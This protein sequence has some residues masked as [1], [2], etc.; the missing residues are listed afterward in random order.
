MPKFR[1]V[2]EY[3]GTGYHGWQLQPGIPTVQGEVERV[4][5]R[6]L[7]RPT[8]VHAAGRTDAGVHAS[9]QVIHFI[10]EWSH[11]PERLQKAC[12]SLLPGEVTVR[13]VE[14][15]SP[16]FHA[17]HSAVSKTY[18]Y[19]ILS[20]EIR[21][22]LERLYVW[23]VPYRLD[24][25]AMRDAASE[26]VGAHDFAAF[27]LATDGTPSTVREILEASW[28]SDPASGVLTFT[29]RGTGFLRYMVRSLVGTLVMVGRG[30]ISPEDIRDILR[31]GDR[32]R[33]GPTAPARGLTL[34]RVDYLE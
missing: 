4:L 1:A 10:A 20:R 27:G 15:A 8:R 7:C 23:H 33:S 24:V 11:G 32:N 21:S 12:N 25:G 13:S 2:L 34:A 30:K 9:G 3:D 22:S 6:I 14:D 19:R 29:V 5:E 28:V 17:R 31:S 16:E 26:V 18:V